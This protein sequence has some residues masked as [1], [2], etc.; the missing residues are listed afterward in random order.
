[1]KKSTKFIKSLI[2]LGD[3]EV[4]KTTLL[5]NYTKNKEMTNIYKETIGKI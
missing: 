2:V 1:M 4:G 3:P 5:Y